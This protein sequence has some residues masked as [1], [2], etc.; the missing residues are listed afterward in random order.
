MLEV[1]MKYSYFISINRRGIKKGSIKYYRY[2][3]SLTVPPCTEDVVWTLVQKVRTVSREQLR[4]LRDAV[5][6][7]E[8]ME[9]IGDWQMHSCRSF[10]MGQ[11]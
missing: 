4:L 10:S 6:A 2:I 7:Y 5:K 3:G 11:W 8:L 1:Q 9:G